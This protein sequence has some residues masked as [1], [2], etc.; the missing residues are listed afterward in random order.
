MASIIHLVR[1]AESEHNVSKDFS[2][3][4]PPLTPLGHAQASQLITS[5]PH[6]ERI[7]LILT[8]PLR[9]A[10]QTSLAAFPHVL[11]KRYY[12]ESSGLGVENGVELVLDADLQERSA[13]PCDTGS[14]SHVLKEEFLNLDLQGLRE[15]WRVKAGL[16]AADDDAVGLRAGRV[17]KKLGE[18]SEGL[19]GE[20]RRDVVV[21]THGVFMK[22]L[23]GDGD[24]DLPKAGWRS[25]TIG[26]DG[27][28]GTVLAPVKESEDHSH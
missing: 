6:P 1:H 13:L 14:E 28:D 18:L 11:D 4:D 5:F 16:Y 25:Y 3:P 17:R 26:K 7:A 20:E 2:Q 23:S 24:I 27:G 8:S 15:G 19:R 21:V 10:I 22:F 9:R 12:T